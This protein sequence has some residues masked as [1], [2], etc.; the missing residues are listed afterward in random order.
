M[1]EDVTAAMLV[2]IR[3]AAKDCSERG[4][5]VASKWATDMLLSVSANKKRTLHLSIEASSASLFST[6]TPAK[7]TRSPPSGP[8]FTDASPVPTQP[9]TQ[10][11]PGQPAPSAFAQLVDLSSLTLTSEE[12][13]FENERTQAEQDLFVGAKA[14]FD[15]REFHRA[16]YMLQGCQSSKAIFLSCYSFFLST[17]RQALS[18]WHKLDGNRNQ[19]DKPINTSL[20]VLLEKIKDT[21]DPWLLFLKGLFLLRLSRREEAIE[22]CL[23]SIA[24]YPWNWSIWLLLGNCVNDAEQLSSLMVLM[25]ISQSHPIVQMFLVKTLSD[26]QIGTENE[27]AIC[28]RLLSEEY[29]P[30]SMWVMSMRASVLYN[31]HEYEQ[32]ELQFETILRIDPYRMDDIDIYSNILYVQDDKLKLSRLAHKFLA[33]TRDRP[34]VCL[35]VGN[36]YSL[37]QEHEKAVKYFRRAIELDRT[38]LTAWTLMGHEYVEMK[39]SHAAIE[40]YRR[41][42]DINRKDY[43]A[44]YGLGQ[45]YELLSMHNYALYYYQHATALKSYDVRLWQA[46]GS[47]YEELGRPREAIECYKRALISSELHETMLCLKLAR[48]HSM[49]EEKA[50]AVAYHKRVVEFCQEKN[51]PIQEFAKSSVEVAEYNMNLQHGDLLLAKDLLEPVVTGNS[52]EVT[53]AT[54]L[55]K[56]LNAKLREKGLI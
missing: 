22:A 41:A 37:R 50:E 2:D 8:S 10:P 25:P 33:I 43:R 47:C 6:S 26:L 52:E 29:F 34:E 14:C 55:M 15:A 36:H 9:I 11:T 32:A 23:Q 3:K 4:L 51:R 40:A 28:D 19:P 49:L 39:N 46:Q 45:A 17:E 44:W 30:H 12:Q 27:L 53:K 5:I 48:L 16:M 54:E 21:K 24:K 56:V 13:R 18:D 31:M 38:Y 7:S 35:L 42:V 1:T 20:S